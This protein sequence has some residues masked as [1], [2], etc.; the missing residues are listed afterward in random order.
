MPNLKIIQLGKPNVEGQVADCTTYADAFRGFGLPAP[1]AGTL[2]KNGATPVQPSDRIT[3]DTT[4]NYNA[5][6]KGA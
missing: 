2:L 3:A 5:A 1:A 6:V 4:V